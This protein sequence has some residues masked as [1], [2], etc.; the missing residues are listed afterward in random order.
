VECYF[1]TPQNTLKCEWRRQCPFGS[2]APGGFFYGG[3]QDVMQ[4]GEAAG[5]SRKR[6]RHDS[7]RGRGLRTGRLPARAI[8]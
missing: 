8:G 6:N 3:G 2:D 5:A 4:P 1:A 7:A